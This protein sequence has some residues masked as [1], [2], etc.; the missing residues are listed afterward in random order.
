M[1]STHKDEWSKAIKDEYDSLKKN[2]VWTL[3]DIPKDKKILTSK[4]FEKKD[5]E[6][7]KLHQI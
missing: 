1:K 2:N 5:K 7:G 3:V 6:N 4:I